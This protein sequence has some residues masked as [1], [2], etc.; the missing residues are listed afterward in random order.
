MGLGV[1]CKLSPPL[2]GHWVQEYFSSRRAHSPDMVKPWA[3]VAGPGGHLKTPLCTQ[4]LP[5]GDAKDA[6]LSFSLGK[7]T[8]LGGDRAVS[9][10]LLSLQGNSFLELLLA[11]CLLGGTGACLALRLQ[12]FP[13]HC[14]PVLWDLLLGGY[15]VA[16]MRGALSGRKGWD[17]P[18]AR[19]L[20]SHQLSGGLSSDPLGSSDGGWGEKAVQGQ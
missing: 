13:S 2:F 9:P 1:E 16:E 6:F 20:A 11:H 14:H 19:R 18:A 10:R 15:Q 7:G 12:G 3:V 17:L 8:S 5:G 4:L